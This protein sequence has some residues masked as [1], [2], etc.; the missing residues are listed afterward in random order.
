MH[1]V[2]LANLAPHEKMPKETRSRKRP[3]PYEKQCPEK[4]HGTTETHPLYFFY[5]AETTGSDPF[6][7]HIIKMAA[8]VA[9][10]HGAIQKEYTFQ[11][12]VGTTLPI[13]A[14]GRYIGCA[15][16]SY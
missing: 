1:N 14:V 4:S 11:E 6:K 8:T 15:C 16:S 9:N 13:S 5:K 7:D 3:G 2:I 12:L 10:P